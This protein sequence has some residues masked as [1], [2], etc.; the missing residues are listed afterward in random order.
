MDQGFRRVPDYI[1]DGFF[2]V[3]SQQML[4]YAEEWNFLRRFRYL[5]GQKRVRVERR[6]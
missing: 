1:T 3:D 4:E 5:L 2:R 6:D